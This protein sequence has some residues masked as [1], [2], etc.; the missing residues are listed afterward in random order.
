MLVQI[1]TYLHTPCTSYTQVFKRHTNVLL[2]KAGLVLLA[3][4]SSHIVQQVKSFLLLYISTG[5]FVL[6]RALPSESSSKCVELCFCF[7]DIDTALVA[8]VLL[9][10]FRHLDIFRRSTRGNHRICFGGSRGRPLLVASVEIRHG[11]VINVLSMFP[12]H[13]LNALRIIWNDSSQPLGVSSESSYR[14]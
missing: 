7:L 6:F 13:T 3:R 1:L 14:A 2:G 12:A 11:G 10:D 4:G 8:G 9:V 5:L